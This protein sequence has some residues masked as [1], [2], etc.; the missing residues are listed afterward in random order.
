MT[1]FRCPPLRVNRLGAALVACAVMAIAQC[2]VAQA[3]A[4]GHH[5]GDHGLGGH[6]GALIVSPSGSS[7]NSGRS[8]GSATYSTIQSAVDAA[9]SGATVIVCPGTYTEDVDRRHAAAARSAC[10]GRR[11]RDHR[12]AT[13]S[14]T[15]SVLPGPEAPHAWPGSPSSPAGCRSAASRSPARSARESSPP[16]SLAG[17]SISHVVDPRQPRDRQR[18][19]HC[20]IAELALPAVQSG[21]RDSGRLR[22]GGPPHG[23]IRLPGD[24][25]P[26]QRQR[27]RRPAHGRVRA[28]A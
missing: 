1:G 19:R 27:R 5:H 15:S 17:G 4:R 16:G 7:G 12:R 22:R 24:R 10:T 25:Q 14:A 11:F 20:S 6:R 13:G 9:S 8:C 26:H 28:D 2:G 18:H 3:S 23:R 21:G